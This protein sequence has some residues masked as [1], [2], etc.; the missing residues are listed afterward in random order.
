VKRALLLAALALLVSAS[1]FSEEGEERTERIAGAK[2]SRELVYRGDT[3]VKET[4]F[5]LRGALLEEK[6]FGSDSLPSSVRTY[7]RAEG[8]LVR[9]D[10]RD[11]SGVV[12]GTMSY[13]YDSSGRLLGIAS[14]GSLGSGGAGMIASGEGPQGSWTKGS[15]TMVLAYDGEGRAVVIQ[16]MKDGA[17]LSTEKRKY[18]QGGKLESAE[19]RDEASGSTK[20]LAYDE[21]GRLVR[22]VETL[23]GKG[24]I[25]TSYKYDDEGR[26]ADEE[27][28]IGSHRR[29]VTRSYSAEGALE[30]VETRQD[31]VLVLKVEYVEGGR[32]EELYDGGM[33]F[34]RATWAG[35]RKV[36]DEF[37][38][39]GM[40]MRSRSYE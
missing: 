15:S 39:E 38:D 9:V 35:G 22:S 36:K 12:V 16:E 1:A 5:D 25:Q 40:P 26:L 33:L 37:F 30:G 13:H 19:L 17:A 6:L 32:I 11:S 27:Q 4:S 28:T 29:L 23:K 18:G 2:G 21:G 7:Q 14:E 10:E 3:L 20:K 24:E 31:G 34:V 8:R